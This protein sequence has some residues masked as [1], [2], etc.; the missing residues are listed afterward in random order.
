MEYWDLFDK[1]RNLLNHKGIRGEKLKNGEY[2]IVIN[3][4]IK[5]K[6]GGIK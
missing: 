4:W 3:A 1:E 6:K 2:H 5:N